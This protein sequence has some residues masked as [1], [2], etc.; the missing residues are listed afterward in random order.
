MDQRL[1]ALYG[2]IMN[3]TAI[4]KMYTYCII[5]IGPKTLNLQKSVHH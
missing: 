1:P 3:K 4:T 5:A 2:Q